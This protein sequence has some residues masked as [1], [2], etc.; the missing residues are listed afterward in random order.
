[1]VEVSG[2]AGVPL[3]HIHEAQEKFQEAML[4]M[5][6]MRCDGVP[7]MTR[8]V[9]TMC[10]VAARCSMVCLRVSDALIDA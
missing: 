3:A 1:M 7:R 6:S 10:H 4:M 8:D 2:V 5:V 9:V